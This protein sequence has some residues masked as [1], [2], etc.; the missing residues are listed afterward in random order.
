VPQPGLHYYAVENLN[1]GR[2][3]Q[4]G[5]TGSNAI[6]FSNLIL[7]P[8]TPYRIWLLQ[9]STLAVA[10]ASLITPRNGQ[11]FEVP[12]LLLRLPTSPDTDGDGLHDVGEMIV[13]TINDPNN[14]QTQDS[15]GDGIL[16]GAE[17]L[18]GLNPLDGLAVRTG[19]VGAADTPGTAVDLCALNDIVAVADSTAG[20]S[21]FN[22]F[23]GMQPLAIAQVDTPGT[24]ERVA[25]AGMLV[26]VA[27]GS[28]G[29]SVIDIS[30]PPA[31]RIVHQIRLPAA[32]RAVAAA[33]GVAYIGM[34]NGQL[35][36]ID[37]ASAAVLS[38]V[39]TGGDVHDVAIEGDVVFALLANQLQAYTA[40]PEFELQ[41]S[42]TLSSFPAEGITGR[43]RLFVGGDIAY[44]TSYPGFDT[45]NVTNPR[46][47]QRIGSA[48]D[49]GPNSFKQ[50]VANGSGLGVAA[51]GVNPRDDGTHHV[52]L[53]DI[54]DPSNTTAFIT[55]FATPGITRAVTIY[56]GIAY[57][58]DGANGLQVVNYRAFDAL[59]VVP[60]IAIETSL[61]PGVAEE[62]Q[63]F[64]VTARVADDVQVRNVEFYIDGNRV[65]TDGNFPFEQRLRAPFLRD[66]PGFFL[67]ARVSDTGGNAT[68]SEELAFILVP[69]A[70]PPRVRR[71]TPRDGAVGSSISTVAAFFSE[72]I[73]TSTITGNSFILL[74]SGSDGILDTGD[75]TVISG[76][77]DYLDDV[78]GIFL[79]APEPLSPGRYRAAL[80]ATIT[81]LAGNPLGVPA[82]WEFTVYDIG[83]DRDGDGVPDDL[84]PLLGLD[85][86]NPD[87]DGNGIP[88]GDED[89][90]GDG[91]TNFGEVLLGT[92][93][94]NPD[95]NGNGV[96]DGA[97]DSDGDGLTDSEE[98]RLGTDA[99]SPD[100][101]GD[102][103]PDGAEVDAGSSPVN[104]FSRPRFV[105]AAQPPFSVTLQAR[106]VPGSLAPNLT[107]A[108]PPIGVTV[109]GP[110]GAGESAPNVII[111]APPVAVTLQARD[112]PGSLAP[113][114]TIAA[115]PVGITV[116]GQGAT[117]DLA[118]NVTVARPP[119]HVRIENQ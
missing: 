118:P 104:R 99:R 55:Q 111:A 60:T 2:I 11:R 103:W 77:V 13:G 35:A 43:K 40:L 24:A 109:Q 94:T 52:Y 16:D 65:A 9:A 53:Y 25:C 34:N 100:S 23:N 4:R 82:V 63:T 28:A 36:A 27:G 5:T 89:F 75:D 1:T 98:V 10:S 37:L 41:G 30:G 116:Q 119:V 95:T 8:E 70:T 39:S 74:W 91:L 50:I 83:A 79:T 102:G 72:S 47:M 22:V 71:T 86:D 45:I 92:D 113:N 32:V 15:D 56:N 73:D 57:A 14:P 108:A 49:I 97:E 81:D 101:D 44:V 58:A 69:D 62:G 112:V 88:D 107:I 46:A 64:R 106:D 78:L 38:Q 33:G 66:Q 61:P 114:L 7:A 48:R 54:A 76:A 80:A 20:V 51:V 96:L 59:G 26:A 21:V 19:V 84:E 6:A 90:D 42:A 31:A 18:Q 85:P 67:Q 110:G 105:V 115:P 12:P 117:G 29:L 17:V 87:T 93:A 3:E 68:F